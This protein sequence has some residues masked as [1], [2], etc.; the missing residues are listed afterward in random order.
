[1]VRGA[2]GSIN[3]S[4]ARLATFHSIHIACAVSG[5]SDQRTFSTCWI[6]SHSCS[7]RCVPLYVLRL[8]DAKQYFQVERKMDLMNRSIF[9][10]VF[11]CV[12]TSLFLSV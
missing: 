1:M 6:T 12:V 7:A 11:F 10:E 2:Q 3:I 5:P 9:V 4:N 8:S